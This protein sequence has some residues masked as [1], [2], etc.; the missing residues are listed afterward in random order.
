[1]LGGL[2]AEKWKHQFFSNKS[3]IIGIRII[4]DFMSSFI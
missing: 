2:D 1:M 3:Y 4:F